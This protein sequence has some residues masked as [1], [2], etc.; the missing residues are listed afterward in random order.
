M[1]DK[2]IAKIDFSEDI[3]KIKSK[4]YGLNPILGAY[5]MY[6]GKKIKFWK[7]EVLDYECAKEKFSKEKLENTDNGTILLTNDKEGLFVKARGGVLKITEV[8]GENSKRMNICDFLRGN[9][10]V[11][12]ERFI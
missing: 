7:V 11:E 9:K 10:L 4:V 8:Q 6:N 3:I 2:K 5:V 12:G 1:I